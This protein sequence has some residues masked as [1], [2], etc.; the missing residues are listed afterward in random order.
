MNFSKFGNMT[1]NEGDFD[2]LEVRDDE[3]SEDDL[4][5]DF[6]YSEDEEE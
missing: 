4:C 6:V 3:D 1:I 2:L 5:E